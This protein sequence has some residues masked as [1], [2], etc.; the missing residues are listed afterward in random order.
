M[1]YSHYQQTNVQRVDE[2]AAS[3]AT[4]VRGDA[5]FGCE[6]NHRGGPDGYLRSGG[7]ASVERNTGGY[8]CGPRYAMCM[9]PFT[10]SVW[11]VM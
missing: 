8:L 4:S 7:C 6:A 3:L 1:S 9:P 5:V 2:G 10:S 11:P